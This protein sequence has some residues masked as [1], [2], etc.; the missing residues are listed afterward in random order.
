[1]PETARGMTTMTRLLMAQRGTTHDGAPRA[2][3]RKRWGLA[4]VATVTTG[5][6]LAACSSSAG[7]ADSAESMSSQSVA[8]YDTASEGM[9]GGASDGSTD[10]GNDAAAAPAAEVPSR[11]PGGDSSTGPLPAG[12]QIIRTAEVTV[13]VT[14]DPPEGK[15][16]A[17]DEALAASAADAARAVRALVT[18]PGGYVS[19]SDGRGSTITVTLR[20]PA[21]SYESVM[22]RL[23]GIGKIS[24]I[25]ESTQDVTGQLVDVKSRIAS[26]QASVDRLRALM[27]KAETIEDV[28]SIESELTRREA[29]L[30]SL[31]QQQ[32]QLSDAV[33]LSTISVT[34]D[35]I[36]TPAEDEPEPE[37]KP[38]VKHNA[39]MTG[40]LAGWNGLVTVSRAAAT[41]LGGLLPFLIPLALIGLAVLWI[42]RSRRGR[43]TAGQSVTYPAAAPGTGGLPAAPAGDALHGGPD[44][45]QVDEDPDQGDKP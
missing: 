29:D 1:M 25:A 31:E 16:Q 10:G 39:F 37:P 11:A 27:A 5:L 24:D 30:E 22:D 15:K 45:H 3:G 14:V 19:G 36:T 6:A 12:R 28:I 41:V 20:I 7:S 38:E 9:A 35:A 26:Q 13:T 18:L 42:R 4:L 44:V 2:F 23:G 33:A 43:A 8:A 34:V 32:A 21:G 17:S 40:L